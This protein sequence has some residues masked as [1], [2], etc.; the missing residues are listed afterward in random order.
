M[1][2]GTY[3]YSVYAKGGFFKDDI[4]YVDSEQS[5]PI[6]KTVLRPVRDVTHE[7][8][9]GEL[10]L[11]WVNPNGGVTCRVET[12]KGAVKSTTAT[13]CVITGLTSGQTVTVTIRAEGN[14]S[15]TFTSEAVTETITIS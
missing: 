9:D 6:A 8:A 12:D 13:A 14:G 7:F 5:A 4:Y 1:S 10:T 11:R 3:T 15:T 2:A